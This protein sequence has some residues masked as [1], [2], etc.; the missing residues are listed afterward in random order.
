M[1]FFVG[2]LSSKNAKFG[3]GNPMLGKFGGK[4][5]IF[6]AND[7][8][9]RKFEDVCGKTAASCPRPLFWPTTPLVPDSQS[10]FCHLT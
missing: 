3:V 7:V 2:K 10:H 8:L 5:E 4:V 1:F 6:S 9:C